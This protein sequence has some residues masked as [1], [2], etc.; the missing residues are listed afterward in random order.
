MMILTT[1]SPQ[2]VT[3]KERQ[4]ARLRRQHFP[5]AEKLVFDKA[6][7]GFVP[8]PILMR[9]VMRYLSAVELRVLVYLQTRCGPEMVC[10]PTLDEIAH[11]LALRGTKNLT[12]HIRGLEAKKF[13]STATRAGK[14]YYLVHDPAVAIAHMVEE[15]KIPLPELDDI[16]ELLHDLHRDPI[17]AVAKPQAKAKPTSQAKGA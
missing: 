14:K 8:L 17:E 11:D 9:K 6:K 2:P 16:N 13:I 12:P 1:P 15:S 3:A 5:D 10:F 7:K 4:A